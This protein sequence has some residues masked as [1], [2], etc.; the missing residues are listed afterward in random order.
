MEIWG[1]A[2]SDTAQLGRSASSDRTAIWTL[3]T[4]R[5]HFI[6]ASS[7]LMREV[8]RMTLR[9]AA[10]LHLSL[11][12]PRKRDMLV[13]K[14]Y[15]PFP[16]HRNRTETISSWKEAAGHYDYGRMVLHPAVDRVPASSQNPPTRNRSSCTS[17][18]YYAG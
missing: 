13:G 2:P 14:D 1:S 4:P 11:T 9:E 16:H 18:H 10:R 5:D 15:S 17:Q 12:E 7:G 3:K 8:E 6:V